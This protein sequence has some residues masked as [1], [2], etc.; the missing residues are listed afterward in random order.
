MPAQSGSSIPR[1]GRSE[2]RLTEALT[3]VVARH[4]YVNLTVERILTHA[5]VSRATFYQYFSS[6]DDCF[7]SAYRHHAEQLAGKVS[8]AIGVAKDR[9]IAALDAIAEFAIDNP[10]VARL[11][12]RDGLAAGPPGL[13]ERD[14]LIAKL[15]HAIAG[16]PRHRSTV[17]LRPAVL[18]GGAMRFLVM[19]LSDGGPL[20]ALACELREWAGA[21]LAG[22]SAPCWSEQL[23]PVLPEPSSHLALCGGRPHG[24]VRER[25]I[26][27]TAIAI[28]AKGYQA[29][30]VT[31]IV[32]AAGVSRRRFYDEFPSKAYAFIAAYEL[33]FQRVLATSTPAFFADRDWRERMWH[34]ALAFTG[35]IAREPLLAYLGFVECYALGP[36][37]EVRV[38][39]TQLA[40]TLFLEDGQRQCGDPTSLPR[41]FSALTTATIFEVAFQATRR[42]PHFD[43]RRVQP[44]AVYIALAP[45]IGPD[46]AGDFV[47]GKLASGRTAPSASA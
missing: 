27:G 45:V 31:D 37:F 17:D 44:L 46:A 20:D 25:I 16:D 14:E 30:T 38:H 1:S 24:S 33:A 5:G 39:D 34:A 13:I 42:S 18:V 22:P 2:A 43:I 40:F 32:S 26:A 28:R 9:E 36:D 3:S 41:A 6:A 21:F 4:G 15:A 8:A 10:A 29:I 47:A 19:R 35:F 11:L 7:L 23:T 12:A